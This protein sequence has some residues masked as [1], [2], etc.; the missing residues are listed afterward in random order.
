MNTDIPNAVLTIDGRDEVVLDPAAPKQVFLHEGAYRFEARV[1]GSTL[2]TAHVTVSASGDSVREVSLN[3][4]SGAAD[5]AAV[6]A[7]AVAAPAP[8]PAPGVPP[9]PTP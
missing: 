1:E 7:P 2:A 9:A 6:A 5:T 4:P 3:M 8:A